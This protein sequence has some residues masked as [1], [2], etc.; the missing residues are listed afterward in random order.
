MRPQLGTR[1]VFL[2]MYQAD[3][4]TTT[5]STWNN[6]GEFKL[7]DQLTTAVV[8]LDSE[9]SVLAMNSAAEMLLGT[10]RNKALGKPWA[11]LILPGQT[12]QQYFE[13]VRDTTQTLTLREITLPLSDP[14]AEKVMVDC[15]VS[16][17]DGGNVLVEMTQVDRL[18]RIARGTRTRN[19]HAANQM[20][21]RGL[22]HEIKNPL[23]GLRGAAQ[24]LDAELEDRELREY[25][26]IITH[27]ADRLSQL[28][29]RMTSGLSKHEHELINIHE[30]LEHVRKLIEVELPETISVGYDYDPSLP[31]IQA[32]RSSLVQ[33]FINLMRN[34]VEALNNESGNIGICTRI[35]RQVTIGHERHR[36]VIRVDITDN[37]CGVPDEIKEQVF[38]PM[39]TGR[40][41]GT[42]LGLSIAQDIA[43]QHD[44]LIE[45]KSEA[46]D[47]CFSFYLPVETP[48]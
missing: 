6:R 3:A 46:G 31:E 19:R 32:D 25:T 47:T 7:L 44:G 48:A 36:Q 43:G 17:L 29:D 38:D 37:G 5:T 2:S 21:M 10:S 28:V 34:A 26:R 20:V 45:F 15:T 39:V 35:D 27:E 33:A 24:L 18:A 30:V 11:V 14:V 42:G 23:G 12:H 9:L 8:W 41:D 16:A 1:T 22:A 40:A 4:E 13:F